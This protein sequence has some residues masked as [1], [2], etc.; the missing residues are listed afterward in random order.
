MSVTIYCEAY[1]CKW[2]TGGGNCTLDYTT[3]DLNGKCM[4]FDEKVKP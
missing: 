1:T 3:I 2:N 4:G